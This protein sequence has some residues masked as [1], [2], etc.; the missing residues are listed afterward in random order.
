[1][2]KDKKETGT[3]NT[4]LP[5]TSLARTSKLHFYCHHHGSVTTHGWPTGQGEH[6]YQFMGARRSE[7]IAPML[8]TRTPA[9]VPNHP[10]NT[11]VQRANVLSLTHCPPCT[12]APPFVPPSLLPSPTLPI[13]PV[14]TSTY[15][16]HCHPRLTPLLLT[17]IATED[18]P[19]SLSLILVDPFSYLHNTPPL[20]HTT[21]PLIP[22]TVT[23]TRFAHI[24]PFAALESHDSDDDQTSPPLLCSITPSPIILAD[25]GAIHVLLRE[26]VFPFLSHLMHP[27][28][29][30][31]ILTAKTGGHLHFPRLPFPAPFW[32]APDSHLHLSHS[33]LFAISPLLQSSS[34]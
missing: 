21:F 12:P 16:P 11:N 34:S 9:A 1:M 4:T 23:P 7:F 32:S 6:L 22:T 28:T 26:S 10:G 8:A 29:L 27:A 18:S 19:P 17:T 3:S 33:I 24:N 20:P 15:S 30:P 14:L 2:P 5:R 31:P 13:H 25:S